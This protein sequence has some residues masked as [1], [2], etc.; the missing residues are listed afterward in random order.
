MIERSTFIKSGFCFVNGCTF[1]ILGAVSINDNLAALLIN[2]A[3][4][5]QAVLQEKK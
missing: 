1:I 2:F 3:M 4:P 5:R